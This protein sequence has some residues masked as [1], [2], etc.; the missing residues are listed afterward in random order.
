MKTHWK[1]GKLTWLASSNGLGWRAWVRKG[2]VFIKFRLRILDD[3]HD[4]NHAHF[5]SWLARLLAND[6]VDPYVSAYECPVPSY[7]GDITH[8]RWNGFLGPEFVQSVVN[9]ALYVLWLLILFQIKCMFFLTDFPRVVWQDL[10]QYSLYCREQAVC[11]YR[12][13]CPVRVACFI[14]PAFHMEYSFA[15]GKS[16]E[17]TERRWRRYVVYACSA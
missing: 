15:H 3:Y 5:I 2:K 8:L 12:V 4:R 1:I 13:T 16:R 9:T 6:R 7:V 11:R 17:I 14:H 10:C